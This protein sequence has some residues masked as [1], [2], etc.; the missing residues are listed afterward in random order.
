[1]WFLQKTT[2]LPIFFSI[3]YT[4]VTS[5]CAF[6]RRQS[7]RNSWFVH[8]EQPWMYSL[9]MLSSLPILPFRCSP[10]EYMGQQRKKMVCKPTAY[11]SNFPLDSGRLTLEW[12]LEGYWRALQWTI[13]F[14]STTGL[15]DLNGTCGVFEQML[16]EKQCALVLRVYFTNHFPNANCLG[17]RSPAAH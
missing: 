17:T 4:K 9:K 12:N 13:W 16:R 1:M 7:S 15:G 11:F 3:P 8:Y 6:S 10:E 14:L 5:T 2:I